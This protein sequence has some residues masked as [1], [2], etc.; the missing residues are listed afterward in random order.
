[1][2]PGGGSVLQWRIPDTGSYPI[3]DIGLELSTSDRGAQLD[4]YLDFL[5]WD[6]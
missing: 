4:L 5:R 2:A 1:V 3:Y 6:G